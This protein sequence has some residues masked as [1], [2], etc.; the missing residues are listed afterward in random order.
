MLHLENVKDIWL[1]RLNRLREPKGVDS[2]VG[3]SLLQQP[4]DLSS[5]TQDRPSQTSPD[6]LFIV[7]GWPGVKERVNCNPIQLGIDRTIV[8]RKEMNLPLFI[9]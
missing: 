7:Y 5:T 2:K 4:L 9:R 6:H 1:E 3:C 8:N